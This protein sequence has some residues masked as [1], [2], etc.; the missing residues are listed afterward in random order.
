M[1]VDEAAA[2]ELR[3][4]APLLLAHGAEVVRERG[5]RHG[6]RD[7]VVVVLQLLR[8]AGEEERGQDRGVLPVDEAG[9]AQVGVAWGPGHDDVA[10][11]EVGMA[12]A[13][14]ST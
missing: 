6:L 14:A 5:A 3:L 2:V 4:V 8:Y 1:V 12:D 11:L 13:E 9:D 7:G 10:R